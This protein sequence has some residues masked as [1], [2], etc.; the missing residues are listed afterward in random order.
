MSRVHSTKGFRLIEPPIIISGN[1]EAVAIPMHMSARECAKDAAVK[2]DF[3]CHR[4]ALCSFE[5]LCWG[6][7]GLGDTD[8]V[9]RVA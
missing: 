7:H 2:G 6:S 9:L 8:Y 3:S 5:V 1:Q 4:L